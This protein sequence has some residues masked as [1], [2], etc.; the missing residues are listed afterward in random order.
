MKNKHISTIVGIIVVVL[1]IYLIITKGEEASLPDN[2]DEGITDMMDL[3]NEQEF[4]TFQKAIENLKDIVIEKEEAVPPSSK[5]LLSAEFQP[6]AQDVKGKA[7]LLEQNNKKIIR[8]EDF[9]T[10]N[11]PNLQV[12][13]SSELGIMDAVNLGRLKATKGNFNYELDDSV[14]TEKYNKVLV[15]VGTFRVLF[16]YAELG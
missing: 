16:S 6:R 5:V 8:F 4:N 9:Y 15:W 14:D 11:G 1:V 13:L 12:Y 10:P 7:L 3:M 2:S